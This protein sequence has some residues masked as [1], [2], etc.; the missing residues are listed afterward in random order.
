MTWSDSTTRSSPFH[1]TPWVRRLLVANAVVYLLGITV[2]TEQWM[3]TTLGFAPDAALT[4]PWTF[5]TYMFVHAGFLHLAFNMLMLFFFGPPVEEKMGG[6]AFIRF[7]LLCGLGGPILAFG[8]SL[9]AHVAP[10]VGAS[11]AV[12]GVALAFAMYWP[13]T[14]VFI[15]PFPFPIP[16]RYLVAGLVALDVIPLALPMLHLEDGIAHLAHLGGL[17]F[18]FAYLRGE[19][20]IGR[21]ARPKAAAPKAR[22]LVHH[23]VSGEHE[24]GNGP[25]KPS[26]PPDDPSKEVD[27]VLDKISR[28][29]L[30]SLTAAERRF[31][32]EMSRQ[33][34][35][36]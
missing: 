2:F 25:T 24:A 34:R 36:H 9:F 10:F 11:A 12:F 26:E 21:A 15:F 22:V 33:L 28:S 23:T 1:L 13:N 32:D 35:G 30:E 18:A 4:H 27:R 7:Y 29:G 19:R 31:L 20:V 16:V 3:L 6:S 8:I 17:L 5:V 14:Q